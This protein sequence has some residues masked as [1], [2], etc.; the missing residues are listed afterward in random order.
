MFDKRAVHSSFI[1]YIY[2]KERK[3]ERKRDCHLTGYTDC[4]TSLSEPF[5]RPIGLCHVHWLEKCLA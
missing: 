4:L 2:I 3:R 1:Y 5:Y